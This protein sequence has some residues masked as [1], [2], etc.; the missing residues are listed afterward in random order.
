[1][2]PDMSRPVSSSPSIP[3]LPSAILGRLGKRPNSSPLPPAG[4]LQ[5]IDEQ[6]LRIRRIFGRPMTDLLRRVGPFGVGA[7]P[8]FRPE[9]VP[10]ACRRDRIRPLHV[11]EQLVPQPRRSV[12][13]GL[14]FSSASAQDDLGSSR[15]RSMLGD[16][17]F[18]ALRLPSWG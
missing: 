10:P 17:D 2:L 3:P 9:E 18:T 15:Y 4:M 13:L 1:M 11:T 16:P 14:P 7:L 5:N 12:C 6:V 8:A